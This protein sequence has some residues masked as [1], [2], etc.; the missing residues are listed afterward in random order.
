MSPAP[1][2]KAPGLFVH[3]L[4]FWQPRSAVHA[5]DQKPRHT[6]EIDITV[7]NYWSH[8]RKRFLPIP[9]RHKEHRP[10]LHQ[11]NQLPRPDSQITAM[12]RGDG[13]CDNLHHQGAPS[14]HTASTG[15]LQRDANCTPIPAV[16]SW[17]QT[18]LII[19]SVANM[20]GSRF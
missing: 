11:H 8:P 19:C 9:A 17:H 14:P 10:S 20:D 18:W 7:G 6:R 15:V 2:R 16:F 13:R 5:R 1:G 4:S 12:F 3:L